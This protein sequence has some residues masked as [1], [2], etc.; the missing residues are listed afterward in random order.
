[1]DS[2]D[3]CDGIKKISLQV[4]SESSKIVP[5]QEQNHAEMES[6]Q[7]NVIEEMCKK[8]FESLKT[9]LFLSSLYLVLMSNVVLSSV[10]LA[11]AKVSTTWNI[12]RG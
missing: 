11:F 12:H 7:P 8:Y 4:E 3:H 1:M 9:D 5:I 2:Q 10:L 6:P